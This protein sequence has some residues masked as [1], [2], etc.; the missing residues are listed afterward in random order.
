MNNLPDLKKFLSANYSQ[1]TQ[2]HVIKVLGPTPGLTD[3]DAGGRFRGALTMLLDEAY[4]CSPKKLDFLDGLKPFCLTCNPEFEFCHGYACGLKERGLLDS[5]H[6]AVNSSGYKRTYLIEDPTDFVKICC[7]VIEKRFNRPPASA[8]LVNKMVALRMR[9]IV[10]AVQKW[11][12]RG[13]FHEQPRRQRL[14][15]GGGDHN[16]PIVLDPVLDSKK[17]YIKYI[18]DNTDM[19]D[20]YRYSDTKMLLNIIDRTDIPDEAYVEAWKLIQVETVMNS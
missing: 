14:P 4:Q 19:L 3:C 10:R 2:D 8:K 7:D 17:A 5:F 15:R 1:L 16:G 18:L 20:R 13:D 9:N 11:N 6:F 12:T